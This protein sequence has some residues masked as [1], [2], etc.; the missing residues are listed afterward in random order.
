MKQITFYFFIIMLSVSNAQE[1]TPSQ[2]V[3]TQ[4]IAYNSGD[5]ELFMSVFSQEITL[6]NLGDSI[7]W[8]TGHERVR[9]I[10]KNLFDASPNLNSTVINRSIIGNKVIDYEK[11]IGRNNSDVLHL[12]MIYEVSHGKIFRATAIRE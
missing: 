11:I 2:V 4:L 10:Y 7:P 3:E 5:I 8:A 6:W 9:E 12:I 1:P